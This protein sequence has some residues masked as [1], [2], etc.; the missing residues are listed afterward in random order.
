M[1]DP[2]NGEGQEFA[3]PSPQ[4]QTKTDA[5]IVTQADAARKGAPSIRAELKATN[6]YTRWTCHCC[7]GHTEKVGVLCEVPADHELHAGFRV[8]ERCLEAGDINARLLKHA[9][10]LEQE[11][12]ELRSLAGRLVVPSFVEWEHANALR[13]ACAW[14]RDGATYEEVSAWPM[15]RQLELMARCES[16][17]GTQSFAGPDDEGVPC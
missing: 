5:D 4:E 13:D 9:A 2:R 7:G 12:A 8:C 1:R 10:Q 11:A 3:A 15:A 6:F 14:N 16:A 17:L